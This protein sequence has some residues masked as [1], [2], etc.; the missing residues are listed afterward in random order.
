MTA[1]SALPLST[2]ATRAPRRLRLVSDPSSFSSL[3]AAALDGSRDAWN[4]LVARLENVAWHSIGAFGL[5]SEDRQDAFS[6]TFFRLFEKLDTIREPDKLPGW[7]ATTARNEARTIIRG[8]QR[9]VP[10]DLDDSDLP[11]VSLDPI[12]GLVAEQRALALRAAL[13][14][15]SEQCRDLLLLLMTDPPLAYSEVS[16]MLG[17]PQGSLGPTRQRCLSR[18]RAMPELAPYVAE[19]QS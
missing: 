11:S 12:A 18:L 9:Q 8:R 14:N 2:M 17:V 16:E 5:S 3:T 19:V 4:E 15:L 10:T 13:G 6:A 1:A 7:V